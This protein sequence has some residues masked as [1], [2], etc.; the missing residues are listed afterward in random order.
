M[1]RL[2]EETDVLRVCLFWL[3]CYTEDLILLKIRKYRF[4]EKCDERAAWKL[5]PA[6]LPVNSNA[7]KEKSGRI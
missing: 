3:N 2:I 4:H 1:C 7:W 5:L 6:G